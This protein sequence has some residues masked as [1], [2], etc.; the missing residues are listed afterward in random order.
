LR[1]DLIEKID[2]AQ[3]QAPLV[4]IKK[5]SKEGKT[6]W[7][8]CVDFRMLNKHTIR[9]AYPMPNIEHQLDVGRAKFFTKIDLASAFWQIPIW[10]DHKIRTTFSF[11]GESYVWKVMPFGLRNAPATF[12]RLVDK[13][14]KGLIGR[15]IYCYIDDILIYTETEEEHYKLVDEI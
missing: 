9:D 15:G 11:E 4:M 13:I 7:R 8:L 1:Q 14:L 12:Q 5:K 10:P 2:F 3:F 6:K